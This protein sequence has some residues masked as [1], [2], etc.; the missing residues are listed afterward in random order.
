MGKPIVIRTSVEF[1][2]VKELEHAADIAASLVPTLGN[3]ADDTTIQAVLDAHRLSQ[4][5]RKDFFDWKRIKIEHCTCKTGC[6]RCTELVPTPATAHAGNP[7][8]EVKINPG[9]LTRGQWRGIP[10]STKVIDVPLSG[11]VNGKQQIKHAKQRQEFVEKQIR[12]VWE[13]KSKRQKKNLKRAMRETI[14]IPKGKP[15]AIK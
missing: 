13:T 7:T 14:G 6:E 12:D 8:P 9:M 5:D 2:I 11:R 15:I 1:S 3:I 10:G 4:R